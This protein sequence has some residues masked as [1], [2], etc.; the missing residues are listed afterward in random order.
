M[1]TVTGDTAVAPAVRAGRLSIHLEL[2]KF[3]LSALVVLTAVAGFVLASPGS[4]D[5]AA[6]ALTAIGTA[7]AAGGAN[8]L[9]QV[10]ETARDSR[11][12]RTR[13]RPLPSGRM[14]QAHAL[15]AS[16]VAVG[17]G[18]GLLL[19]TVGVLPAVLCLATAAL[20]VLGYTPLKTRS[21]LCTLVGA[22]VGA[23]P[24]MIG[25]AA[26]AG[27]LEPGAWLLAGIMFAWQIPHFLA[28]AWLYR[29]DYERGGFRMLPLIDREGRTT[30]WMALLYSLALVPLGLTASLLGV[31][32]S[33]VA[34]GAAALGGL[35]VFA[36]WKLVSGRRRAD[37]RRVFFA[38]LVYLPALLL[39]LVI[40]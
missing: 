22:V 39:L 35:M 27:R 9:N 31:T 40:G 26:A 34:V 16:L 7:L 21:S 29:E 28:L 23:I 18:V 11:M 25:W 8:G 15:R 32:G 5:L 24:P 3:R 38:S 4:V 33:V 12:E 6:L 30:C 19:A 10:I 13:E 1:Q 17:A 20:Y 37:A 36:S 2:W 14:T